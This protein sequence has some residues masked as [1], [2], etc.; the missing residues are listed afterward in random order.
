MEAL[1][2]P[3][4]ILSLSAGAAERLIA[5]G[6]GDAALFYLALLRHGESTAA[7]QSLGWT[8]ERCAAALE[9]LVKLGLAQGNVSEAAAP[10]PPDEPPDYQ[11]S[12]LM[13]ALERDG[14]FAGLYKA[15]ESALGKPLSEADLKALYTVYDYLAFPSELVYALVGWCVSESERKYGPGRRPRMPTVKKEAFRWKRLG[16][17]TAAAA[18]E[19]LRSQ[20]ALRGREADILPLLDIRDRPA[21]AREREYIAGWA[22]MGFDDGAIRL[23]YERTVLQKQSLNWA[24]MNA[25]LK[26]WHAA[27]L[28]TAAQVEAGDRQPPA[29]PPGSAA[30][31]PRGTIAGTP[32]DVQPTA[33]RAQKSA[34]WLEEFLRQQEQK[35]S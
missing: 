33:E 16:V 11:R 9:Q 8:G 12:D 26:R 13:L 35:G 3:E 24:Y 5:A 30:G 2:L 23:A 22:D 10:A 34:D 19:F 25:I 1:V 31:T 27:G 29:R 15:V 21:V 7:R 6:D 17:D 4:R 18:E 28:H 20:Q 32:Q 14:T